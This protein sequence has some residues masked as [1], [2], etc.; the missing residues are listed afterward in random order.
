[1]AAEYEIKEVGFIGSLWQGNFEFPLQVGRT[2]EVAN[3]PN[4]IEA[5]GYS[6]KAIY[7]A[8]KENLD[9]DRITN[10][11]PD[12]N[13]YYAIGKLSPS[14]VNQLEQDT[15]ISSDFLNTL[16][17]LFLFDLRGQKNSQNSSVPIQETWGSFDTSNQNDVKYILST[18]ESLLYAKYVFPVTTNQLESLKAYFEGI[19]QTESIFDTPIKANPSSVFMQ[20]RQPVTSV[21]PKNIYFTTPDTVTPLSEEEVIRVLSDQVVHVMEQDIADLELTSDIEAAK[22][23]TQIVGGTYNRFFVSGQE[24]FDKKILELDVALENMKKLNNDPIM[25]TVM[26]PVQ[27]TVMIVSDESANAMI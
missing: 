20:Q 24:D 17:A 14:D 19:Q 4:T 10:Q 18:P 21:F 1:M 5:G 3:V 2:I 12:A 23:F 6:K 25:S 22:R 27:E 13:K 7:F 9:I 26:T 15:K 16:D 11:Y 8:S